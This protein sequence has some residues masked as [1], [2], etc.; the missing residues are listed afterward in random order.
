MLGLTDLLIWCAAGFVDS[1]AAGLQCSSEEALVHLGS[2]DLPLMVA[3]SCAIPP[4]ATNVC[5]VAAR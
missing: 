2:L 5:N 1:T 3:L 4:A